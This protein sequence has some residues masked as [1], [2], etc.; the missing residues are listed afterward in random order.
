LNAYAAMGSPV[1]PTP[2]QVVQ[3]NNATE[4]HAPVE[5]SLQAGSLK[6]S[7]TPN[8]LALIRIEP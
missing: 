3:L 7:L 8:T 1:D 5:T 2:A 4:F 6:L